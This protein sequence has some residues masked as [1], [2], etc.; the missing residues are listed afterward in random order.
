MH[1]EIYD[2]RNGKYQ[3]GISAQKL[4]QGLG[5]FVD[6]DLA[7]Y[8]SHWADSR[9]AGNTLVYLAHGKYIY[10]EW[11]HNEPHGLNV[12]RSGDTVLVGQFVRGTPAGRCLL[13]FEKHNFACIL[14]ER[15]GR[16]DIV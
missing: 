16:W 2:Y 5:V 9:L 13:I 4:R 12:F 15:Q 7:F 6:D 14:G 3:G 10:G 1:S 8:V 11:A